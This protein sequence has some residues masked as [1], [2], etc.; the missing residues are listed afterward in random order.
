M[1]GRRVAVREE[2]KTF[3]ECLELAKGSQGENGVGTMMCLHVS[4][5]LG[6]LS[7]EPCAVRLQ[8]LL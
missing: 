8:Q 5:A 1:G 4:G 3:S 2:E 6:S 7:P